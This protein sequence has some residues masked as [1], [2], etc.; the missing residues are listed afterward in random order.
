MNTELDSAKRR[1]FIRV[2][3]GGVL[4]S[5]LGMLLFVWGWQGWSTGEVILHP[6][7]REAYLAAAGGPHEVAFAFAVWTRLLFGG[8]LLLVGPAV[9]LYLVLE[10]RERVSKGLARAGLRSP[11]AGSPHVPTWLVVVVLVGLLS[12]LAYLGLRGS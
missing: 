4:V 12:V 10:P 2:L 7:G 3:V 1:G 5:V 9:L 8:V 6:K 11:T